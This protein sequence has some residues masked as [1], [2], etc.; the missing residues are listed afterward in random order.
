LNVSSGDT[1][2]HSHFP[3]GHSTQFIKGMFGFYSE[4][5]VFIW[6]RL[7]AVA[8]SQYCFGLTMYTPFFISFSSCIR[9]Q[10][11]LLALNAAPHTQCTKHASL[12]QQQPLKP[13]LTNK[14]S[15]KHPDLNVNVALTHLI[16]SLKQMSE[17]A[18][19]S[20]I[21]T[22]LA[23]AAERLSSLIGFEA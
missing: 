22:N 11:L 7:R 10:A 3:R 4:L 16:E 19:L 12:L 15:S 18:E 20:G 23:K 2:L 17:P 5:R 6:Y 21:I 1:Y 13:S 8:S 9:I 14:L